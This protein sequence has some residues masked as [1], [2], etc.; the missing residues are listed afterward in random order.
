MPI[1]VPVG[2]ISDP[3]P[4][5]CA[6]VEHV[7]LG[8]YCRVCL[9]FYSNEDMAKKTHC[10]SKTHYEKLQVSP[11]HCHTRWSPAHCHTCWKSHAHTF[12]LLFQKHLEKEKT[13]S[14]KKKVKK[15]TV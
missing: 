8:Y 9:L 2:Q 11:A 14:E 6:G 1:L 4:C 10:S 15:V 13:K 12:S 5:S 3:I 7:K